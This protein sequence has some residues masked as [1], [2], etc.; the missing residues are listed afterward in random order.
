MRKQIADDEIG[1]KNVM[2][3]SEMMAKTEE[4]IKLVVSSVGEGVQKI[5]H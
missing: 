3:F 1:E 4:E 5:W 2:V